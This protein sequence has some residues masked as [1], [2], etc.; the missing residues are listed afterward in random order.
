MSS[1]LHLSLCYL[2][3]GYSILSIHRYPHVS[4]GA[5]RLL[6]GESTEAREAPVEDNNTP[7]V[8]NENGRR[9]EDFATFGNGHLAVR[10]SFKQLFINPDAK[11]LV[12]VM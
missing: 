6:P 12:L 9:P 10:R 4:E 2:C 7:V 11:P 5:K 3:V 1:T 8:P